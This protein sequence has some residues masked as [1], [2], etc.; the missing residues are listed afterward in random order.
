MSAVDSARRPVLLAALLL[1][2]AIAPAIAQEPAVV[3]LRDAVGDAIDRAERDSFRLFPNTAGFHDAVI[4]ALPGPEFF[5]EITHAD[6]DTVRQVYYRI[7]PGQLERIRSLV[8][9][10][11]FMAAQLESDTGAER[12]LAAFWLAIEEHPLQTM[13]GEA[14]EVQ[15]IARASTEVTTAGGPQLQPVTSEN[16]CKYTLH[17]VTCGSAAGGFLGS[18][19]A[20][21]QVGYSYSGCVSTPIYAVNHPVFWTAT[22]GLTA[23]GSAVGYVMGDGLDH[24]AL[25]SPM[26]PYEDDRWRTGCAVGAAI[27]GLALGAGLAILA[28][29]LHWGRADRIEN[30]PHGLTVLPG[31]LTGLCVAVE[32]ITIGYHIG[33]SIDRRKAKEAEAKRRA[34]GR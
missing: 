30:D 17:G 24:E 21:E 32:I 3:R 6:G 19:V 23:V 11:D 31:V 5:A 22:C 13:S 34:L 8:D 14:P 29:G 12:S 4:L 15:D 28:G 33:R 9:N 27:P 7:L 16:R 26:S 1:A 2:A 20:I 10:R 18:Q 25:P